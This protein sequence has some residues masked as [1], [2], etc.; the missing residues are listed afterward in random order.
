DMDWSNYK[1]LTLPLY[2]MFDPKIVEKLKS[3]VN[4]GGTLVLGYRSGIKDKDHWMVEE[5]VPGVFGEMAGVEV[6]QFEAPATAK[7]GIRMGFWPLKGNKFCEIL[8]PKTAK[9]LARYRDKKKFYSGKPAITVNQYG[10]GKVYYVG[11]SLTPESFVL[12]YRRILKEA[13][14]RF[15]L[16][17]STIERHTREG[18]RFNYEIT[19][20]HS[21][22]YK[23]AGLSI[24]KP[25]GYKIK[26]IEK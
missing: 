22:Q 23:L 4:Q 17:G 7:V 10:K 18:K 3:Y 12:L 21:N 1:V 24:L 8:E 9:V 26:K 14:V 6:F 2:T 19:M 20:N 25:F 16:L 15:S 13:G 11:T 5:P